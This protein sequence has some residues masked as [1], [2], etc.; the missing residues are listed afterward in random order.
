MVVLLILAASYTNIQ[1]LIY[2]SCYII[3]AFWKILR[4]G[5]SSWDFSGVNFLVQ[6]FFGVLSEALRIYLG[7]DF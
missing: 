3:N 1:F 6:G 7:F 5:N 4:L 2:F